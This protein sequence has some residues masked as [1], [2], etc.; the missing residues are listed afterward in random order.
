MNE[1]FADLS[2]VADFETSED[3][4]PNIHSLKENT[5]KGNLFVSVK[6]GNTANTEFEFLTGDSCAFLPSGSVAYQQF[7]H[8]ETPSLASHLKNM[9]YATTAIHPY[10]APLLPDTAVQKRFFL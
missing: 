6:G 9:G 4:M 3:Y 10:Y 7:L 1:A 2:Y 5:V 8:K